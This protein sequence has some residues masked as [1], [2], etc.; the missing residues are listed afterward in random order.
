MIANTSSPKNPWYI[1]P[2]DDKK[3]MR[4]IVSQ[5]ILQKLESLDLSYP[6][7]SVSEQERLKQYIEVIKQ[8]DS[9]L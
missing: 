8:Q 2:A 4:L 3:N 5:I 1:V 7:V 9:T 6:T